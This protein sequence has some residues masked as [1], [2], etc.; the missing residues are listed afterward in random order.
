[1]RRRDLRVPVTLRRLPTGAVRITISARRR[2]G[3]QVKRTRRY[4]ACQA[5]SAAAGWSR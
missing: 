2:D 1:L 3:R 4:P 5:R